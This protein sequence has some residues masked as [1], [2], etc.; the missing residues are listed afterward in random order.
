MIPRTRS[1]RQTGGFTLIEL[2]VST[3]I[4]MAIAAVALSAFM[5]IRKAINR[6]EAL[7]GLHQEAQTIYMALEAAFASAQQSCA[8]VVDTEPGRVALVFMRGKE[9]KDDYPTFLD[10]NTSAGNR[11]DFTTQLVWEMWEW[12]RATASI[13]AAMNRPM[14]KN[15]YR[16]GA[17]SFTPTAVFANGQDYRSKSFWTYPQPRR[18]LDPSNPFG[19]PAASPDPIISR[20]DDNMWFPDPANPGKSLVKV[21]TDPHPED[22]GDYSDLQLAIAAPAFRNV[23]DWSFQIVMHDETLT[24][25]TA[26]DSAT[27]SPP[28]VLQGAWLDGRLG[29]GADRSLATLA[30]P[31]NL[32][33]SDLARR[34][35]L[36]RLRFTLT[37]PKSQ[38]SQTFSYS[39]SWPGMAPNQ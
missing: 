35:R 11:L 23:T 10:G 34:P 27:T 28:V 18:Y 8:V 12:R 9:Q 13:H 3:S 37:E 32:T 4:A 2:L 19:P 14:Q 15:L 31:Q 29:T 6:S 20:L 38:A 24:P 7:L 5:Q 39:F 17:R 21:G 26:D 25:I 33:G 16:Y 1:G 36:L 30:P 22:I